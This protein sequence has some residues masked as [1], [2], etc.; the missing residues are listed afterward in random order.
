MSRFSPILEAGAT[1]P[2]RNLQSCACSA[3]RLNVLGS[4]TSKMA[5]STCVVAA[6]NRKVPIP[7][8]A[9]IAKK[10]GAFTNLPTAVRWFPR[11]CDA[12]VSTA[13]IAELRQASLLKR[14]A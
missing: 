10:A 12:A 7:Y 1:T 9:C 14:R 2:Q 13:I 3:G 5:P 4:H 8:Q 11:K 6:C